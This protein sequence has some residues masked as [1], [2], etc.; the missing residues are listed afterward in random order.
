MISP[1]GSRP[2]RFAV[3]FSLL[4]AVP[5]CIKCK[6][7]ELLSFGKEKKKKLF[8]DEQKGLLKRVLP[9]LLAPDSVGF[10]SQYLS[11]HDFQAREI[12]STAE[13]C[14]CSVVLA[15]AL[16]CFIDNHTSCVQQHAL[17]LR[18]CSLLDFGYQRL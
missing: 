16:L 11:T 9:W 17:V 8:T 4:K 7:R 3:G 14:T 18:I 2:H 10:R 13:S 5:Q 12:A 1:L 15:V 6:G